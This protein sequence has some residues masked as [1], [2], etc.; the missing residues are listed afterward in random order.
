MA[1]AAL[2]DTSVSD[3]CTTGYSLFELLTCLAILS[4]VLFYALPHLAIAV[5][6]GRLEQR[7]NLIAVSIKAAKAEAIKTSRE[8]IICARQVQRQACQSNS[9]SG[10]SDWSHGWL[11]FADSNADKAYQSEEHLLKLVDLKAVHCEI[12]WN[13]GNYL[14]YHRF[15]ILQGSRA[16]S[17]TISCGA[18]Q[19]QLVINWVGRVRRVNRR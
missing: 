1:T 18:K 5:E 9:V 6:N 16:G 7:V 15:G 17:F 4:L 14:S 2:I 3:R 8:I 10:S 12:N 13:R 19:T 11:I